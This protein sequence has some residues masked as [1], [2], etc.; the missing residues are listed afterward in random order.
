MNKLLPA[1][2]YVGQS[3]RLTRLFLNEFKSCAIVEMDRWVSKDVS[4]AYP[5]YKVSI[6]RKDDNGRRIGGQRLF[7]FRTEEEQLGFMTYLQTE[8]NE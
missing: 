3:D 6:I 8:R 1:F 2:N 4:E 5:T 7:K